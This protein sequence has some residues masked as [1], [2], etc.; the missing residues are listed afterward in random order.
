MKPP[1]DTSS[2]ATALTS[3]TSRD[4]SSIQTDPA[5]TLASRPSRVSGR[6][7]GFAANVTT[8]TGLSLRISRRSSS[9][10]SILSTSSRINCARSRQPVV[11]IS[12]GGVALDARDPGAMLGVLALEIV[13]G[14]RDAV[15]FDDAAVGQLGIRMRPHFSDARAAAAHPAEGVHVQ[16]GAPLGVGI[17][18]P[19]LLRSRERCTDFLEEGLALRQITRL[20]GTRRRDPHRH[21]DTDGAAQHL[22]ASHDHYRPAAIVIM[23]RAMKRT[24]VVLL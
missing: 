6:T 14:N 2:L 7:F 4:A 19:H 21:H 12:V 20:C 22:R 13:F 1:N 24:P 18:M 23:S 10:C 15:A 3:M 17:A 11:V 5:N 9:N 16:L 8:I